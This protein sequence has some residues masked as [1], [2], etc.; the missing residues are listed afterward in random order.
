MPKAKKGF[1]SRGRGRALWR[2][3]VGPIVVLAGVAASELL[4]SAYPNFPE[5]APLVLV[6]A[7]IAGFLAELN[8]AV[9]SSMIGVAYALVF[10]QQRHESPLPELPIGI[11]AIFLAVTAPLLAIMGSLIR[12]S[13]NRNA[14]TLKKHLANTPLG[15]IELYE[16][17]EI[18]LWAGSAEKIFHICAEHAVG[19][20]LF[21]VPGIF[22]EEEDGKQVRLL[23]ER[24]ER[25]IQTKAVLQT[26]V[27]SEDGELDCHS[28]WFWSSTLDTSGGQSRFLVLVED[29]TDRVLAERSLA[30]SKLE[31]IERL[32]RASELRDNDTGEHIVRMSGYAEQLALAVG[33][34]V[35]ECGLLRLA[36]MMHDIGKI[37]IPDRVLRKQGLLTPEEYELIKAHTTI[38]AQILAGSSHELVQ[39]AEVIAITHH[40]HWD[41][42]GYPKGLK[43][44]DIPLVGRICAVCDVFDALTSER[45]YKKAWEVEPA[46]AEL[47]RLAG[48]HLDPHLVEK[49]LELVPY[50]PAIGESSTPRVSD[51]P[52]A[53]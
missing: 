28:R 5:P 53:A 25:G 26:E 2:D 11:E 8:S 51:Q 3:A 24:L 29:I 21:D 33:L 41:G 17:Y 37:G 19:K 34:T 18:R 43:G 10:V 38:G 12:R 4:V 44:E 45:P 15:V 1:L 32:V 39:M 23:L 13:A 49:F 27:R 30:L 6:A 47:R 35:A 31:I 9:L 20:N 16:D 46:T 40:E 42:T 52:R 36:A 50:F 22:F 48:T 14:E 7:A